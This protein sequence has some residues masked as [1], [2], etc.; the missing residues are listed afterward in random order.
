M[1]EARKHTY[2]ERALVLIR[3]MRLQN[4]IHP[5]IG[6]AV[7]YTVVSGD[8][9]Y[10][11]GCVLAL[12][13]VLHSIVTVWNDLEDEDV[14]ALNKVSIVATVRSQGTYRDITALLV[15]LAI[16]SLVLCLFLPLAA[17]LWCLL[18]LCIG[19]LYN[20]K[21][22][23]ASRKPIGSMFAMWLGYG[24]VP[25]ALGAS[26]GQISGSVI[27]LGLGWSL[28]RLS[29]SILKDFK[30]ATGDAKAQKRTFLLVFGT[31]KVIWL[32]LVGVFAGLA[33]IIA[34]VT[35]MV[36]VYKLLGLVALACWL[37]YE[38][39]KLLKKQTYGQLNQ[40]FHH[41]LR[42]QLLFDGAILLCLITL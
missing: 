19:W 22:V 2:P 23:Q 28:S 16:I 29:L 14:D 8:S 12:F 41:C 3:L 1:A 25:F 39:T 7:G 24:V 15:I 13:L 4:A 34:V 42:Y 6:I 38:R 27:A 33:I 36:S 9:V 21:P 18:F 35:T 5:L 37:I 40:V 31:T 10:T 11:L 17:L 20:A 30:D 26:F 32:S